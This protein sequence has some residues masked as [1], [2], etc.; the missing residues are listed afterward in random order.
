MIVKSLQSL[1]F[2]V[3]KMFDETDMSLDNCNRLL[4]FIDSLLAESSEAVQ[5]AIEDLQSSVDHADITDD[6]Y[7]DYPIKTETVRLAITA[8]LQH[9][10]PT[11]DSVQVLS[12]KDGDVVVITCRETLSREGYKRLSDDIE[13][14]MNRVF[15]KTVP[16]VVLDGGM[17]IGVLR[18]NG[19]D[20]GIS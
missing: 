2:E 7:I 6:T 13:K 17:K 12:V 11:G 15:G 8:L 16:A 10:T 1:R 5:R 9:K 14:T 20:D 3:E 18:K 19:G 4:S